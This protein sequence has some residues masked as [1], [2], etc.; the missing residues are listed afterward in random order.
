MNF[1]LLFIAFFVLTACNNES[2]KSGYD[3]S[4]VDTLM[5]NTADIKS[6]AIDSVSDSIYNVYSRSVVFFTINQAEFDTLIEQSKD[7]VAF[8]ESLANFDSYSSR[9]KSRLSPYN[10]FTETVTKK[11]FHIKYDSGDVMFNR[12]EC[13]ELVGA[14]LFDGKKKPKIKLGQID[15]QSEYISRDD[16]EKE[17]ESYFNILLP[18]EKY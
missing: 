12:K 18:D 10:I 14:I 17:I 16:Y 11:Y 4:K 1:I 5:K 2:V 6:S 9:F 3:I 8:N 13:G 15:S 7:G